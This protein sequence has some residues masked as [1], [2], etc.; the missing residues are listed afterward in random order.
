MNH[1]F[2][3]IWSR[4]KHTYVVVSE[5][6]NNCGKNLGGRT[7]VHGKGILATLLAV[8]VLTSG[9]SFIVSANSTQVNGVTDKGIAKATTD[10]GNGGYLYNSNFAP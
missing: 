3:V 4:V 7:A 9:G 2:K 8:M 6:T 1:I 10:T 5:V